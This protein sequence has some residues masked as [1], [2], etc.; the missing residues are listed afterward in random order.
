MTG[1]LPYILPCVELSS[2]LFP[3]EASPPATGRAT[4][5]KPVQSSDLS[6]PGNME[7]S[8]EHT[9]F[10]TPL[11][12]HI[13]AQP[14]PDSA[15]AHTA[16]FLAPVHPRNTVIATDLRKSTSL[17]SDAVYRPV[18]TPTVYSV[19]TTS[20][21]S[22]AGPQVSTGPDFQ[23]L[24]ALQ[25]LLEAIRF[26]RE[27]Y[28]RSSLCVHLRT[29]NEIAVRA[30]NHWIPRW[31]GTGAASQ[32]D[33][34]TSRGWPQL[35]GRPDTAPSRSTLKSFSSTP[36]PSSAQG[37]VIASGR[38]SNSSEGAADRE[39]MFTALS[40][41]S[42][43][44]TERAN[45]DDVRRNT[46]RD[47]D[48]D[49]LSN[50]NVQAPAPKALPSVSAT[51]MNAGR[52]ELNEPK[53]MPMGPP[54]IPRQIPASTY[55]AAYPLLRA[56]AVLHRF[57]AHADDDAFT[58]NHKWNGRMRMTVSRLTPG[59]LNT[60]TAY[61]DEAL[62]A[63][64]MSASP[65][66][67]PTT[68]TLEVTRRNS[69]ISQPFAVTTVAWGQKLSDTEK[70]GETMEEQR[71][72]RARE[73]SAESSSSSHRP[74]RLP[75]VPGL[76]WKRRPNTASA[77][78]VDSVF[79]RSQ[80][81]GNEEMPNGVDLARRGS[82]TKAIFFRRSS[83]SSSAML[84]TGHGGE[85]GTD[86]ISYAASTPLMTPPSTNPTSPNVAI[87]SSQRA[88]KYPTIP[89]AVDADST[90][91]QLVCPPSPGNPLGSIRRKPVP[92]LLPLPSSFRSNHGLSTDSNAAAVAARRRLTMLGLDLDLPGNSLN[93]ERLEIGSRNASRSASRNKEHL[94]G[95]EERADDFLPAL[96]AG[97]R[98]RNDTPIAARDSVDSNSRTI[99]SPHRRTNSVKIDSLTERETSSRKRAS[100]VTVTPTNLRS[101]EHE[102]SAPNMGHQNSVAFPKV[103]SK[104]LEASPAPAPAQ[105][106]TWRWADPKHSESI[107]LAPISGLVLDPSSGLYKVAASSSS[108]WPAWKWATP[109]QSSTV[110]TPG[111]HSGQAHSAAASATTSPALASS[112]ASPANT[113]P[114]SISEAVRRAR[115]TEQRPDASRAAS[116]SAAFVIDVQ[117]H[118]TSSPHLASLTR[119]SSIVSGE[120]GVGGVHQGSGAVT[121]DNRA[122]AGWP[123]AP[124][125]ASSSGRSGLA[126]NWK[127]SNES[128]TRLERQKARAEELADLAASKQDVNGGSRRS[129]EASGNLPPSSLF[130]A[131]PYGSAGPGTQTALTLSAAGS[132]NHIAPP[133]PGKPPALNL[134]EAMSLQQTMTATPRYTMRPQ[135]SVPRLSNVPDAEHS[136][137]QAP[138]AASAEET[139]T[140]P[141]RATRAEFEDDD[142]LVDEHGSPIAV[143]DMVLSRER[144]LAT[145]AWTA[146][147][148][149]LLSQQRDDLASEP[150]FSGDSNRQHSGAARHG[151]APRTV[152]PATAA[153]MAMT[154]LTEKAPLATT[155]VAR[156]GTRS[157]IL[158]SIQRPTVPADASTAMG[159]KL[160][161][162]TTEFP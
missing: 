131:S 64:Q 104:V 81:L 117:Q 59:K 21:A 96:M 25:G 161:A 4:P 20:A 114:P 43:Q 84:A 11:N 35:P 69:S 71:K 55:A 130:S 49:N 138:T 45:S 78:T 99:S 31:D 15:L 150:R 141:A 119:T 105:K 1:M 156:S 3:D 7:R 143:T 145:A 111:H 113:R 115:L 116:P 126:G 134:H 124:A 5:T 155:R 107:K 18:P 128:Q 72:L 23:T 139:Q 149:P 83:L 12:I 133:S 66:S 110:A 17:P 93:W 151:Q 50:A 100:T 87:T 48:H 57:F 85:N 46:F 22:S 27:N 38:S 8:A 120:S 108:S 79:A 39:I 13:A 88:G 54:P 160:T 67:S 51:G 132:S 77:D 91:S 153:D 103:E 98:G 75:A 36:I 127:W 52:N 123:Q 60:V 19:F 14:L 82:R 140:A 118:E 32:S 159:S 135:R 89:P 106:P 122:N 76:F 94:T 70:P 29:D 125:S 61:L 90:D 34:F 142:V 6:V 147:I 41:Y 157:R 148:A 10:F 2:A 95:S 102:E 30:W 112:S 152:V 53:L 136:V 62:R 56:L 26:V 162:R 37:L 44:S 40:T 92:D 9:C 73:S 47:F 144:Q 42:L 68:T 63:K 28:A 101:G 129:S 158:N 58:P 24:A 33:T 121:V 65:S 86:S 74:G 109:G 97:L 16:L 154:P 80:H 146:S 137:V